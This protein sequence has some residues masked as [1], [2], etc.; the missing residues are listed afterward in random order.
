MDKDK[1][2]YR[3]V[4]DYG[5]G[6]KCWNER[7]L[8]ADEAIKALNNEIGGDFTTID[9]CLNYDGYIYSIEPDSWNDVEDWDFMDS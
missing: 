3:L 6:D 4:S 2:R 9:E 8:T 7:N 1:K 5:W